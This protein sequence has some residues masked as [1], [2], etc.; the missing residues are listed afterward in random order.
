MGTIGFWDLCYQ[1]TVHTIDQILKE[2][3]HL[4]LLSK[5]G[6][7]VIFDNVPVS[8]RNQDGRAILDYFRRWADS[9]SHKQKWETFHT[10]IGSGQ[11]WMER[12]K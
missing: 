7:I 4:Y 1:D 12:V 3:E 2:W 6:S 9:D 8:E 11:L 5:V 10:N